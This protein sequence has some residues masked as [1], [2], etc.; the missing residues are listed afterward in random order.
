MDLEILFLQLAKHL[1]H[2]SFYFPLSKESYAILRRFKVVSLKECGCH[3][4][5]E[6][7]RREKF[8][9]KLAFAF[10]FNLNASRAV[11]HNKNDS[12]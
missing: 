10:I 11:N 2:F 1:H 4:R 9:L 8:S 3:V 6:R 5:K 12:V 7:T